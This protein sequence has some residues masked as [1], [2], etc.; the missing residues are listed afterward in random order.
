MGHPI[1]HS[2]H[3]GFSCPPFAGSYCALSLPVFLSCP[4]YRAISI[5]PRSWVLAVGVGNLLGVSEFPNLT[6]SVRLTPACALLPGRFLEPLDFASPFVGVGQTPLLAMVD[7]LGVPLLG[8][9]CGTWPSFWLVPY[10]TAVGV[11]NNPEAVPLVIGANGRRRYAVP[12]MTIPALGQ[13]SE[14]GS[15]VRVSKETWNV[16]QEDESGLHLANDSNGGGPPVS[17]VVGTTSHSGD[18]ER[19][20]R[21]SRSN[22]IHDSTPGSTVEGVAV[23][24][25]REQ[26]KHAVALSP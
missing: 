21:E 17:R 8:R 12:P 16:L 14:Y 1:S 9:L 7:K 15:K 24:P 25:D 5:V 23:V 10:S 20:A 11:G 26:G 13:L 18:T 22:D 6:A 19:L 4:L 2:T 3:V